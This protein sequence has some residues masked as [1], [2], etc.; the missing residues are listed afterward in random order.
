MLSI[1]KSNAPTTIIRVFTF[2][3]FFLPLQAQQVNQ[4]VGGDPGR[5]NDW[6]NPKNWSL[7]RV[8]DWTHDVL[9]GQTDGSR[10][11]NPVIGKG[12]EISINSLAVY[13]NASLTVSTGGSLYIHGINSF[14]TALWNDGVVKANGRIITDEG[15]IGGGGKLSYPE[16]LQAFFPTKN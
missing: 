16:G 12:K 5:E 11:V 15:T 6:N 10:R 14:G 9:I 7:Q 1:L 3:L 2:A 4:W 13:T 8:P